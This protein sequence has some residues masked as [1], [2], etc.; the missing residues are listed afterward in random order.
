MKFLHLIF[1]IVFCSFTFGQ[2]KINET[3][4]N[5]FFQ[6]FNQQEKKVNYSFDVGQK[7]FSLAQTDFEK[8][9]AYMIMGEGK[10]EKGDYLNSV[11]YL[12]KAEINTSKND[13]LK[14]KFRIVNQLLISYRRAGLIENS[15]KKFAQLKVMSKDLKQQ[16]KDYIL[17]LAQAKI[18]E[19]D[20]NQC[21]AAEVRSSFFKKMLNFPLDQNF[22]NKYLFGVLS[23]LAYAQLK[24][25]KISDAQHTVQQSEEYKKKI[26]TKENLLLNDFFYMN[27][28]IL[29]HVDKKDELSTKYFDSAI[30][31]NKLHQN[32]LILKLILSER[33][34]ANI[35]DSGKQ[36]EFAQTIKKIT[37]SETKITKDLI[38]QESKKAFEIIE[39]RER[40]QKWL[41]VIIAIVTLTAIGGLI[42]YFRNLRIVKAS[43]QKIIEHL[44]NQDEKVEKPTE[45]FVSDVKIA[46]E[47]E[48]SILKSLHKFEHKK[49]FTKSTISLPQMAVLL[50]TN[51]K[52]LNYILKKYRNADFNSY[53]NAARINF[54]TKELHHNPKLRNYKI[55]ALAEMCGYS[56]HSQF[57][58][59]F[60]AKTNISPSQFIS[61]LKQE[62]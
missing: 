30:A 34:D 49:V 41:I 17:L 12:E 37:D 8:G 62:K 38:S 24:C 4:R 19:I 2:S 32:N 15:N 28:A 35:D 16:E 33:L 48:Q 39:D 55:S 60:K 18:Y 36:L 54:I 57:T 31:E 1:T 43:Y 5:E 29:S 47:T 21:K 46:A 22:K 6:L 7:L 14:A 23:Q 51:T 42:Y 44:K 58:S 3:K 26:D 11:N 9:L 59:I 27:K 25:G 20:N 50:N 56:S 53:I 10:Y 61:I 45:N 52:Y 13:S 40:K